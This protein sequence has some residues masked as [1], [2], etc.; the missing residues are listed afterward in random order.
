MNNVRVESS[1]ETG[2]RVFVGDSE[3]KN[4]RSITFEQDFDNCPEFIF[5]TAGFPNIA[6][7]DAAVKFEFTP[8]TSL[9]AAKVLRHQLFSDIELYDAFRSS[10]LSAIREAPD[11]IYDYELAE[12]ILKRIMG[13]E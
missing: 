1:S 2:T 7:E 4:V 8:N 13:K 11:D 3:L 5:R 10:I 12:M 6:V 9:D